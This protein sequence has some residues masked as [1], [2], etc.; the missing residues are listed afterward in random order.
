[1]RRGR[2]LE[3]DWRE[4]DTTE[5]LKTAY[6]AAREGV[7]RTRLHALWLVR[8]GWTLGAVASAVGTH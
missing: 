3:I 5:A 7:P 4:E 6:L 2:V 1:M 8:S